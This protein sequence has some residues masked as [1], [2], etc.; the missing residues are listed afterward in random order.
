M[1]KDIL[2]YLE[3][4]EKNG[5]PILELTCGSDGP[6]NNYSSSRSSV[7]THAI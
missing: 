5:G 7:R 3:Y 2:F 6:D 4:T 1:E